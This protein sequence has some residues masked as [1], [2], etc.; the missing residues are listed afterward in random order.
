[1]VV[2]ESVKEHCHNPLLKNSKILSFHVTQGLL[3]TVSPG[4]NVPKTW[5]KH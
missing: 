3:T 1:M 4:P 2:K 5:C